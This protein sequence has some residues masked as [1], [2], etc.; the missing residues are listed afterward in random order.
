MPY[1]WGK[2]RVRLTKA[3]LAKQEAVIADLLKLA[4]DNREAA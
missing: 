2:Y 3:D 4:Y 1:K